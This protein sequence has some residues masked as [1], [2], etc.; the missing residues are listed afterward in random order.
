MRATPRTLLVILCFFAY[1]ITTSTHQDPPHWNQ[2]FRT[3]S[4]GNIF[5]EHLGFGS[6]HALSSA[7]SHPRDL[8]LC[9]RWQTGPQT[10]LLKAFKTVETMLTV[11]NKTKFLDQRPSRAFR[12]NGHD[13]ICRISLVTS[14]LHISFANMQR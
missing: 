4:R 1:N 13:A 8:F 9:S 2:H 11:S 3:S 5:P 14:P 6:H 7:T 10:T 12:M